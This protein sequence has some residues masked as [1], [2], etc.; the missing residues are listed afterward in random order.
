MDMFDP[1]LLRTFLVVAETR[2]FTA[3]ARRLGLQQSTVSQHIRRLEQATGRPL[4]D[5]DTHSVALT[6]DGE[7][8]TG[9]ARAI[10]DGHDRAMAY[11]AGPELRGRLRFGASEDFVLSRLPDIL[12]RFRSTHPL[13]DLELTVELSDVLRERLLAGELDLVLGKRNPG[14]RHG[15]LMWREPL[16]W[17][18]SPDTVLPDGEP[19]PLIAYPPPSLTR[20]TAL[21]VLRRSGH[22]W[23]VVCTSGSLN[24]V[25]AAALAGLGVAV[26]AASQVPAGLV[27]L[28]PG[29]LPDLGDIE[30]VL[31]GRGSR[32][33]SAAANA[34]AEAIAAA[35]DRLRPST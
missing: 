32:A 13:V 6:G 34:L 9:F 5:R 28:P 3:A 33:R 10:L 24:G 19:V 8:M 11:F 17:T 20:A 29:T 27:P 18:G 1:V 23:R 7:A 14:E 21:D 16:V 35:A 30:F 26:F 31:L 4:F 12:R 2:G 22:A 25:R 15:R